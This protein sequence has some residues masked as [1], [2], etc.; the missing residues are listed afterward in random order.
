MKKLFNYALIGAIALTGS[1]M[2]TSC[3]SSDDAAAENNN[4]NFNPETNEVLTKLVFNVATG[5]TTRQTSNATQATTSDPF[6]GINSA[7]LLSFKQTDD[8][9]HISAATTADKRYDL[10]NIMSAGSINAADNNTNSSHRVIETSLPLNTNSLIFYGKAVQSTADKEQFGHL[11]DFTI[12]DATATGL[13]L[14]DTNIELGSRLNGNTEEFQKIGELLG[15]IL[16]CIMN[17]NLDG[18][19]K[20]VVHFGGTTDEFIVTYPD[21]IYWSSYVTSN[22]KSPVTSSKDITSLEQLLADVYKEMTTIRDTEGELRG[23]CAHS[24]IYTIQ[25]MWS[26]INQIRCAT[27]FCAEEAVAQALAKHIHN[28]LKKYFNGTVPDDGAAVTGVSFL[29]STTMVL[30]N[31]DSETVW[32]TTADTKP[33]KIYFTANPS[34]AGKNLNQ[35][36]E[37]LYHLPAGSAHYKF[38]STK[39]Q[40]TYQQ[41]YN[42]SAV[43][44][45]TFNASSYYYPAELCYFGNSPVRTSSAQIRPADYPNGVDK[46]KNNSSWD[47]RWNETHVISSTQAVAMKNNINYGTSLLKTQIHYGAT[48]L[49]DNNHNI[50]YYKDNTISPTD[51]PNKAITIGATSFLLKGILIGGQSKKVGWNYLPKVFNPSETTETNPTGYIY[52]NAIASSSIPASGSSAPNYTLV[53]DNFNATAAAN[54]QPQDKVYVALELINN[55]DQDFYGEHG[56]IRKGGTFY[57]IGELDPASKAPT[58][59]DSDHPLPPYNA[60]GTTNKV[61]RV[62]IQDYMTSVNF[63]IG[64]YSL[65]HAYLTVP[66]LRY[67]SLTLGLSVDMNWETGIN[68]GDVV[69]GG[70]QIN[71]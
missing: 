20:D 23:G 66:D 45:G 7:V 46:W 14:S 65:Q 9:K 11:D 5:N 55:T 16:T 24:L 39:K 17:S 57:L 68:F 64:E 21:G 70:G 52:D 4:P 36:P 1:T 43:G 61:S 13:K 34:I 42:T 26:V 38:D 69:V 30:D 54:S 6:R 63:T 28:R 12:A 44:G 2:L 31:F 47:A 71:P 50:Q 33:T 41:D 58:W 3:S 51:E 60:D 32:P 22:G 25:S 15:G 40:F 8:S 27:P 56:L 10:E 67:S 59:A 49:Q 37:E 18:V 62:F 29:T 19:H 35:F 53:F 48:S